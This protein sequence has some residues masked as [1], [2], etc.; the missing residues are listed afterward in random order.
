MKTTRV[1]PLLL[2]CA[3]LVTGH[4]LIGQPQNTLVVDSALWQEARRM[5]SLVHLS[6][7][8][9]PAHL[10][11]L[12]ELELALGQPQRTLSLLEG[13]EKATGLPRGEVLSLLG[14]AHYELGRFHQAAEA[15]AQAADELAGRDAGI[16]LARAGDAF[17]RAGE[18]RLAAGSYA[19][20][21]IAVP[22]LA[23]WLAVREARTTSDAGRA[24]ALLA[25]A[26]PAARPSMLR[27]RASVLLT[28]GDSVGAVAA[29]AAGGELVIAAELASA[30]DDSVTGRSLVYQALSASDTSLVR[31]GLA[32]ARKRFEPRTQ[33][34]FLILA[35]ASARMRRR[36]DAV[37]YAERGVKQ[38]TAAAD[39]L[40]LLGDLLVS[41]GKRSRA[42]SVYGR[43]AILEGE[44]AELAV[45]KKGIELMRAGRYSSG[46]AELRDFVEDHPDSYRAPIAIYA[47]ADR[48]ARVGPRRVADSLLAELC[49]R[50]PRHPYAS[51]AR[52]WLVDHALSRG[53]SSDAVA[54]LRQE[55]E[56]GGTDRNLAQFRLATLESDTLEAKGL[57]AAL[58][59]AD[60]LGYYGTIA[61]AAAGMPPM[62][63]PPSRPR[64]KSPL[65]IAA[66]DQLDRLTSARFAT[67][68]ADLVDHLVAQ[69]TRPPPELL[70]LAEGLIRRGYMSEAIRLGWRATRSYTL[71]DPRVLRIIFPWPLRA[72]I[73]DEAAR[74]GVDPYLLAA[75]IRQESAFRGQVVSRAGAYGLMQLMPATAREVARKLGVEWHVGLLVVPDANL[76]IG[77][78]HLVS[79][80]ERYEGDVIPALAAYNAGATPVRR[81]LRYPE[82]GDP[83]RFVERIPYAETRGYLRTVIRNRSLYRAL[84]PPTTHSTAG[85]P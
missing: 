51:R 64:P 29:L 35:R 10:L 33:N 22:E 58:A 54:W 9:A 13:E 23:G 78:T 24:L 25:G 7:D 12:A 63:I 37:A 85:D 6:A 14:A 69:E 4:G 34:E 56:V 83:V 32:M 44:A 52:A 65:A 11:R 18:D 2:A 48:H 30:V 74:Q 17:E 79:L 62:R 3:L 66:L 53:D 60:S 76:H 26:P 77:T 49:G 39:A 84:Y 73:E 5:R 38:D 57:H 67:E 27:T 42:I 47:I 72:L 71:N 36:P 70:D 21:A 1:L 81:W 15:L 8:V 19:A 16:L 43:A 80:L 82:A 20:A 59:R 50:W 41:S 40:L 75:L 46:M 45:Y 61:R 28:M 31:A 68:A 55:V